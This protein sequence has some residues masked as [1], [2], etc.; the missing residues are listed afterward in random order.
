MGNKPSVKSKPT[1]SVEGKFLFV[2]GVAQLVE[3]NLA[4]VGVA[5]S[6]PVSRSKYGSL[7]EMVTMSP[8]HG[9]GHGFESRTSRHIFIRMFNKIVKFLVSL[10]THR[11]NSMIHCGKSFF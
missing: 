5:G 2:A 1:V 3:H 8:C 4:K 9:E 11:I 7:V 6:N 10:D